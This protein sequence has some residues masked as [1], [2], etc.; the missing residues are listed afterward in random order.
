MNEQKKIVDNE[1][2]KVASFANNESE[3]ST[4]VATT[5][6]V[7]QTKAETKPKKEKKKFSF[8]TICLIACGVIPILFI[9]L[10]IITKESLFNNILLVIGLLEVG[11]AYVM[12]RIILHRERFTCPQCGTKRI[13]NRQFEHTTTHITSKPS[14]PGG[15]YIGFRNIEYTHHYTDTY[16]CP[17]CGEQKVEQVKKRGGYFKEYEDGRIEDERTEPREF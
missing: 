7:A 9:L 3:H 15:G 13:H 2:T 6:S 8:L 4:V 16:T 17:E 10:A 14:K 5:A 11:I 1:E 12:Y